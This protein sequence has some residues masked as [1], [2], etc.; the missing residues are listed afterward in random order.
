MDLSALNS[1]LF[2]VHTLLATAIKT[3]GVALEQSEADQLASAIANVSRHYNF[4]ASQKTLDWGNLMIALGV[5]Y[6]PRVMMIRMRNKMEVQVSEDNYKVV[7]P[8]DGVPLH[9]V[10]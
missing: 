2:S 4:G 6:A 1:L 3:P 7:I 5:I 9:T 8:T 10:Q